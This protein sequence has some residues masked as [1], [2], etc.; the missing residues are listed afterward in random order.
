MNTTVKKQNDKK[1][2]EGRK[3]RFVVSSAEDAASIIRERLGETAQVLSVKQVNG[4]GLAR[5]LHSPQLEII[6]TVPKSD[7]QKDLN[8]V[9]NDTPSSA[10][11]HSENS[12]IPPSIQVPSHNLLDPAQS[13]ISDKKP[14]TKVLQLAGF[15]PGLIEGIK[16]GLNWSE[17]QQKSLPHTLAE[18]SNW[19]KRT[20]TDLPH[21]PITNKV[22]FFG[23]PGVGTT[24]A[25]CKHLATEVFI[26]KKESQVLKLQNQ[27]PNADDALRVFCDVMHIPLFKDD[28]DIQSINSDI[29]LYLD[30]PGSSCSDHQ[31]WLEMKLKLDTLN[32]D[33]RVL[34]VN[35]AYDKEMIKASFLLADTMKATHLV[36]THIDEISNY[37]KLWPFILRGGLSLLFLSSGQDV[38]SDYVDKP[39]DYIVHRTFPLI[40]LN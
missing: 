9:T 4:K 1:S 34:V 13:P 39:V 30:L 14:I 38:T 21:T 32:I 24:T 26:N 22:A 2:L 20:Y 40:V 8:P 17:L 18:V 3:F 35:A 10:S 7:E 25:L 11:T 19:L 36:L 16:V 5:F 6:V 31:S 27:N 29:P 28:T 15:D 12:S 33:T 37:S 23:A